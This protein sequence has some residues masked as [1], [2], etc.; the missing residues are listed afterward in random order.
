V[1]GESDDIRSGIFQTRVW[2]RLPTVANV[3]DDRQFK[4]TAV[5]PACTDLTASGQVVAC[6]H[7]D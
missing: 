1:Q 6:I 5:D 4:E 7:L 2:L 3:D